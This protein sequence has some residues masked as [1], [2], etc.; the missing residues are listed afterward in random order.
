MN[1][2][3]FYVDVVL[4][5]D[6]NVFNHSNALA[7]LKK[8]GVFIIQSEH[9]DQQLV[10]EE[11]I[12]R[13]YQQIIIENDIRVFFVDGF[14]IARQVASNPELEFRMQGI[15]FMGAFFAA[16]PIMEQA[17][18]TDEKLMKAIE[19]QLEHKFGAKGR[20][21]VDD[22]L[23]VVQRGFVEVKEITSKKLSDKASE[24]VRKE[25]ALPIMLK[26][27]P[28]GDA[29]TTDIHRFWEQTGNFYAT[30]QGNDNL[31]DPFISMSCIPAATG[32]FRDMAGI[33]F[34]HPVWNAEKCTGCGSC[35]T[36]CPD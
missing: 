19:E 30:G 16:S 6:P 13:R 23:K 17:K 20:R 15:A 9:E 28:K 10:W 14:K 1:N 4:S 24:N 22:N 18:L 27:I 11:Q 7:G 26:Q 29:P 35:W 33:R 31:T 21:I 34:E 5:P 3:Y 8:G 25:A 32:V 36:I 2:E 12:P